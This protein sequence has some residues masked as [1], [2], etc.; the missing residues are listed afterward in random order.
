MAF[1]CSVLL[2]TVFYPDPFFFTPS[3]EVLSCLIAKYWIKFEREIC[4]GGS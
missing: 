4:M 1:T 2:E 3:Y